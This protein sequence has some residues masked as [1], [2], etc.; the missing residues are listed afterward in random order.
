M[1]PEYSRVRDG[2]KCLYCDLSKKRSPEGASSI[3]VV[4]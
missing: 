1:R 4:P 3:V 2:V